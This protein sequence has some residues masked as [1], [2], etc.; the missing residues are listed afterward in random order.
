MP[1]DPLLN[2][3]LDSLSSRPFIEFIKKFAERIKKARSQKKKIE[4]TKKS[5]FASDSLK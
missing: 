2:Y 5:L 4:E 1:S 3:A